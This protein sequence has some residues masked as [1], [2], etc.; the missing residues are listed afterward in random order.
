MRFFLKLTTDWD[1]GCRPIEHVSLQQADTGF[2]T[3][4]VPRA[5]SRLWLKNF[6]PTRCYWSVHRAVLVSFSIVACIVRTSWMLEHRW[7]GCTYNNGDTLLIMMCEREG[8]LKGTVMRTVRWVKK[9]GL[10]LI[11]VRVPWWNALSIYN[12]I[13]FGELPKLGCFLRSFKLFYFLLPWFPLER[14]GEYFLHSWELLNF[15]SF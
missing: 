13:G 2:W 10:F 8:Q 6:T 4:L 1:K 9:G 15:S 3:L 7:R 12:L 5:L 14:K 11:V